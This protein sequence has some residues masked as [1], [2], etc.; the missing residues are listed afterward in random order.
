MIEYEDGVK[1]NASASRTQGKFRKVMDIEIFEVDDWVG[2][3]K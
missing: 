1:Q 3:R 2:V